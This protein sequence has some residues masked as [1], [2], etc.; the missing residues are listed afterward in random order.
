MA[1]VLGVANQ[2]CKPS[3]DLGNS[4]QWNIWRR[5]VCCQSPSEPRKTKFIKSIIHSYLTAQH[6][7]QYIS[8][9]YRTVLL[10]HLLVTA[11]LKKLM[12][13]IDRL[14]YNVALIKKYFKRLSYHFL[15]EMKLRVI[16]TN[17]PTV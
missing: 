3:P 1:K 8:F 13:F 17:V 4:E 12:P 6:W 15:T 5:L 16:G 14:I 2:S 11:L 10:I 9:G 7:I